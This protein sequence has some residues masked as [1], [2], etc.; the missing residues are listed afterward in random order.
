MMIRNP[1][2]MA[3]AHHA[4]LVKPAAQLYTKVHKAN[5]MP[6][7]NINFQFI[8]ADKITAFLRKH[9]RKSK[10]KAGC[11]TTRGSKNKL[12]KN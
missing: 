2:A 9:Q 12:L 11:L 3:N 10:E 5:L 1:K 4:L 7:L 6:Q 8:T